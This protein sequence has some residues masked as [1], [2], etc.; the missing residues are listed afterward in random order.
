MNK[1]LE[2]F[3]IFGFPIR[4]DLSWLIILAL[5][6]F[7]LADGFF[8]A[9]H[10]G[11]PV[12][13]YWSMGFVAAIGLFLSILFHELSHAVVARHY[14]IKIDGITLFI[15]GGV[16]E[17]KDEPASPKVEFLMAVVGPLAS[18]ALAFLFYFL[19]SWGEAQQLNRGL[20]LIF[21]YLGMMNSILAV[22]NIVPAF[23]LD[24]GR[25]FRSI[26]WALKKDYYW[27]TRI[28]A[29]LGKGF[30][31]LL[32]AFGGVQIARGNVLGGGWYILIGFFLKSA[33]AG[34]EMQVVMKRML[35][36]TPV[37]QVMQSQWIQLQPQD[38]LVDLENLLAP[39]ALYSHYPVV[40]AD[41]LIGTLSLAKLNNLTREMWETGFVSDLLDR[42]FQTLVLE[43]QRN[44]WEALVK[45]RQIKASNVFI[46]EA[47]HL[48]GVVTAQDLMEYVKS[49]TAPSKEG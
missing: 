47:D 49:S 45:M 42:D 11:L 7:S 32:I 9:N 38:R 46:V 43:P 6:T 16:A 41:R 14:K 30:G 12:T 19:S 35:E 4:V 10:P 2:L 22:F 20:V 17:M 25:V 15:F 1:R 37:S 33:S 48:D 18:M 21:Y 40:S 26:L 23:P 44:A 29:N 39:K 36:K 27:A 13:A 28:A 3:K 5:V 8:P 24:G 34:S 31:W